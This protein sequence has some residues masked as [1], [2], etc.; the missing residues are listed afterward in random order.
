MAETILVLGYGPVGK[1]TAL[2]LHSE[3]RRVIVAQRSAPTDLPAGVDF[4]RCDVLD[5]AS[6][7][8]AARGVT[9]IVAAFGITYD[10]AVWLKAWPQAV[11]NL[12]AAAEAARARVVF[13]DNLYMLG[14]QNAPLTEDMALSSHGRKPRAR[15][16]A[17]RLWLAARDA[18][19]VK[20]AAVRP[21]DFYGPGVNNAHLGDVGFGRI[22]QGKPAMLIALPDMLHDFAYVPDLARMM[23]TLLDASDEDFG[24]VWNSPCAPT[25]TPREILALG[26]EAIGQKLRITSLPLALL[27]VLGMGSTFLREVHEMRFTFDRPYLVDARKWTRRFWSDVTPF[28]IGA[29][30]T[31][32]AFAA[33]APALA[34]A[35]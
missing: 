16:E 29:P 14:P 13:L 17:T 2:R 35:A 19:R 25:R 6:V 3:G 26:A 21:P 24:Q 32:R 22:A 23:T 33:E 8:N 12:L 15:S 4:V 20:F 9:Q 28:E 30:E 1:A 5:A 27:P 7:R 10:G 31:A 34:R 18:G 11:A